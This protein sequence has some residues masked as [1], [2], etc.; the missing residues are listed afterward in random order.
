MSERIQSSSE[1]VKL[2]LETSGR[3]D[4]VANGLFEVCQSPWIFWEFGIPLHSG[5]CGRG[6]GHAASVWP[7]NRRSVIALK[8]S[9]RIFAWAW[10][11][12]RFYSSFKTLFS[13][14]AKK[15]FFFFLSRAVKS[16]VEMQLPGSSVWRGASFFGLLKAQ[17]DKQPIRAN[18]VDTSGRTDDYTLSNR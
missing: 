13:Y 15:K 18:G 16:R 7:S 11:S 9:S 17:T 5:S 10:A 6:Y 1:R 3:S 8:V 2:P 14:L 4:Q 12:E